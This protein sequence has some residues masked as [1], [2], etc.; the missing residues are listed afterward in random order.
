[1]SNSIPTTDSDPSLEESVRSEPTVP[2]S[3]C[4]GPVAHFLWNHLL[5]RLVDTRKLVAFY[6]AIVA[7]YLG[8]PENLTLW[9]NLLILVGFLPV[10]GFALFFCVA[11]NMFVHK[12]HPALATAQ[13]V[14]LERIRSGRAKRTPAC[15]IYFPASTTKTKKSIGIIFF[16]GALVSHT[17]YASI[18]AGLSDQGILVVM[19]SLEPVRFVSDLRLA[20]KITLEALRQVPPSWKVQ[21]WVLAGHSAGSNLALNLAVE[22]DDKPIHSSISRVVVCGAGR[23]ELGNGSLRAKSNPFRVLVM[24]GSEDNMVKMI[25][26]K[27]HNDFVNHL[28][29]PNQEDQQRDRS[30]EYTRFITIQGGN[31]GQYADYPKSP[32]DGDASITAKEQQRIFVEATTKFLSE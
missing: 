9:K 8:I 7:I 20:H 14:L 16:P 22:N 31:H 19:V 3:K 24:N 30:I 5:R 1:M 10:L 23:N 13:D 6:A 12:R 21:E 4:I 25:G 2:M 15:D 29:P 32:R 26:E 27:D 18:A 28:L 11:V 17:A